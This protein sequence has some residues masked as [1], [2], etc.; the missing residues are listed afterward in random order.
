M[1]LLFAITL[2]VVLAGCAVDQTPLHPEDG[3]SKAAHQA[4]ESSES[5]LI[6]VDSDR[7]YAAVTS[8]PYQQSLSNDAP[9][10]ISAET[11]QRQQAAA[12]LALTQVNA[13]R[14][15]YG[16]TPLTLNTDLSVIALSHVVDM[17]AREVVS[18]RQADGASVMDRLEVAEIKMGSAASLVAGGY[19]SFAE[20]MGSWKTDP[21]QRQ[22]LLMPDAAEMGFAVITDKRSKYGTYY[23]VIF[24][25]P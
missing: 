12:A 23:E 4:K 22:R 16:L 24:T 6:E 21:V 15:E 13:Y 14:A 10:T 1:R 8:T 17:A 25:T 11:A 20:A 9:K 5:R 3:R 19:G 18:T 7:T 2:G